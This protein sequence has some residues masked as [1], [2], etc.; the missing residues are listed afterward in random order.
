MGI[1]PSDERIHLAFN[2]HESALT[3]IVSNSGLTSV[4]GTCQRS[5]SYLHF[6]TTPHYGL[7]MFYRTGKAGNGA[8]NIATYNGAG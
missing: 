3:Y 7:Q 8:A 4:A 5:L 1:S 6:I 2:M